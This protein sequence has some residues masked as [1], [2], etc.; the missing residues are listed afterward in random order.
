MQLVANDRL[1]RSPSQEATNF[2]FRTMKHRRIQQA[3]DLV[4]GQ[5]VLGAI[6]LI[7]STVRSRRCALLYTLLFR[8]IRQH[9]RQPV[10][11]IAILLFHNHFQK[12]LLDV[13]YATGYGA[14]LSYDPW[15][16]GV[17]A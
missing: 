10:T 1:L 9:G 7:G 5:E 12:A 17:V 13:D 16:D 4:L 14:F 6:V 8:H 11:V 15:R 3:R 2:R